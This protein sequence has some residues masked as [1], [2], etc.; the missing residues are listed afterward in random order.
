[1]FSKRLLLVCLVV[2]TFGLQAKKVE[3]VPDWNLSEKEG[4][5]PILQKALAE[6][7]ESLALSDFSHYKPFLHK[8]EKKPC[9]VESDLGKI[10][11]WN[12]GEKL[13]KLNLGL[14]PKEKMVLFMWEPP[15]VQKRIYQRKVHRCFSK[16]YTWDDDLVDNVHVFKFFYPVL[17]KMRKDLVHFEKKKL[18]TLIASNK[19]SQHPAELYTARR[20]AIEF[21]EGKNTTDFTFYG[22]GWEKSGYKTY[23]GSVAD[24]GETL[25]NFRFSFC[26]ENMHSC[27]G[28]VTEKIFDCFAAG[29]VPVYWGASN[30][31][32][33]IPEDCFIDRRKFKNNE[34]LYAFLK[35]MSK[36]EFEGYISRISAWLNSDQA[37]LFSE[38]NFVKIFTQAVK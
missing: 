31:E 8:D 7:G 4:L 32:K 6:R 9:K 23:G 10:V 24:K 25:K 35:K 14:L 1:M 16:V 37:Q 3:L 5:F 28:Y 2:V 13:K 33:Y 29:C 30:V 38:E 26:Y 34:E 20:E 36:E 19:Q 17:Q 11:F 12:I 21:F 22:W 18:C 27:K 15:S